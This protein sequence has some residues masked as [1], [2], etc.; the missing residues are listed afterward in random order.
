VEVILKDKATAAMQ[1]LKLGRLIP[2]LLQLMKQ[3]GFIFTSRRAAPRA[4][5]T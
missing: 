4:Y 1:D 3:T 2:S 5:M